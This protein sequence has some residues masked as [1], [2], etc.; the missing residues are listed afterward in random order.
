VV[1]ADCIYV[2]DKGKVVEKGTHQQ[3]LAANGIY[4]NLFDIQY[5]SAQAEG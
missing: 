1:D 3:L 5:K 4:K 2:F